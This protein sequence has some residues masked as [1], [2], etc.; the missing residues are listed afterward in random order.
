MGL[1]SLQDFLG[2]WQVKPLY[3]FRQSF[4]R[5]WIVD[6]TSDPAE[7]I[8]VHDFSVAVIKDTI[9]KQN[10]MQTKRYQ[11]PAAKLSPQF[12]K[13]PGTEASNSCDGSVAGDA[14]APR[15]TLQQQNAG[16]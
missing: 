4:R 10:A 1:Q 13:S 16:D 7:N 11:A 6:A 8:L 12:T 5:T 9:R 14:A 3:T 15:K 2:D